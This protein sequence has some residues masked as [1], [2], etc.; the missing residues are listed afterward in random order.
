METMLTV[1]ELAAIRHCSPQ[2]IK[3]LIKEDKIKAD[4]TLNA[5]N[6][7]KYLIPLS[8][9]DAPLQDKYL[10]QH[11]PTPRPPRPRQSRWIHTARRSAMRSRTGG[12]W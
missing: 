9:L 11:R 4:R 2:Y 3:R 5:N 6:R 7:P 1:D 12:G 8:S 10:K